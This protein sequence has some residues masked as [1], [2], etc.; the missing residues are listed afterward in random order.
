M[1]REQ[2]D[3]AMGIIRDGVIGRVKELRAIRAF[4]DALPGGSSSLT[5]EGAAGIGK[6][7]LWRQGIAGA[8]A[9]GFIVLSCQPAE[10][11]ARL[12][13]VGLADLFDGVSDDELK[14]LPSVQRRAIEVA[15][16]RA[17]PAG[18]TSDQ[19]TVSAAS[20]HL[21]RSLATRT[22]VLIAIDD[23]QWLDVPTA[24]VVEFA[25]RRS[26]HEP[27]GVLT[28]R[29]SGYEDPVGMS[30][31]YSEQPARL[32]L[33]PMDLDSIARLLD[34]GL[35]ISPTRETIRRV[36]ESA[37]G[38][39]LLAL[40]VGRALARPGARPKPGAP[41]PVPGDISAL[42]RERIEALPGPTQEVL[43]VCAALSRPTL[44]LMSTATV[45]E[46]TSIDAAERA[47]IVEVDGEQV[48]FTHPLFAS[49]VYESATALQRRE[50]H[51]ELAMAIA[52]PEERARHLALSAP[53]PDRVVADNVAAGARRARQ[54]GA[55]VAAAE[56]YELAGRLCPDREPSARVHF[57]LEAGDHHYLAGDTERS[58]EILG[59]A[60]AEAAPGTER[61]D[62]LLRN[63]RVAFY[64]D[65]S[66]SAALFEEALSEEGGEPIVLSQVHAWLAWAR[67]FASHPDSA[68]RHAKIAVQMA[69]EA[70]DDSSL[71]YA[72]TAWIAVEILLGHGVSLAT[73]ERALALEASAEFLQ[74]TDTPRFV[75]ASHLLW[76]GEHADARAQFESLLA[77]AHEKG[78]EPSVY[79]LQ[80]FMAIVEFRDGNLAK[81]LE[82]S[83]QAIR[84]AIQTGA[85]PLD[86]ELATRSLIETALGDTGGAR[87]DGL[88]GL[89]ALERSGRST[90]IIAGLWAMGILELS[91]G[92]Y[93]EAHRH[94]GR[95]W[96]IFRRAGIQEPSFFQ[97]A[98]D[99]IE[100][101]IHLGEARQAE[102]ILDWL[103]E[104]GQALDRAWALAVAG[105]CRG[106][107]LATKGDFD[108]A[109]MSLDEALKQHARMSMPLE[110]GRTLLVQG[111]VRRRAR[112]HR[113]GRESLGEALQIFEGMGARLWADN[114]K[115][116]LARI[117]GR[118]PALGELTD[119]EA[120]VAKLAAA[121]RTNREIAETL[122]M[123]V[124]TVEGH[125]SHAYAKLQI[126]SR[127][128]LAVVLTDGSGS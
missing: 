45:N 73:V 2:S 94:L 89:A 21:L 17:E 9:Q 6:T 75:V 128:E 108:G 81:A 12:S 84:L 91:E 28:A 10:S 46:S 23:V 76:I 7:T 85:G 72:L 37:A 49:T 61:I 78:D 1:H 15:L 18:K 119:A 127:T 63:G 54:R 38:N 51:R 59:I 3:W 43:L 103:E 99:E 60:L 34:S 102:M 93:A 114:A 36:Y 67:A 35:Q 55:T 82:Y 39:P 14:E 40:E 123:S 125:L 105:R 101:L 57:F 111:T 71:A 95:A 126:R 97:F 86:V 121:G 13:Y 106:L 80:G 74:L 110:L 88:E 100:A 107:L 77:E 62:A 53:G 118:R 16:L 19:R 29:R 79:E 22:P 104:R 44:S 92:N 20:L 33:E 70:G 64:T 42:L 58:L 122:F 32:E 69:E 26:N 68:E 25:L 65:L 87:T 8:R 47:G 113:L 98:G 116:E 48:R 109:L 41:L 112:Q 31:I 52:E 4:L 90:Q 27:I 66:R 11:E 30:R 124:R 115:A 117:S 83:S 56:L 5:I 120:G 24:R 50:V 96:S